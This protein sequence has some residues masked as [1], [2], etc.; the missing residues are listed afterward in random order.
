VN[1]EEAHA[2]KRG[3]E[4]KEKS[5]MEGNIEMGARGERKE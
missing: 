3:R 2:R 1:G 5:T 4:K